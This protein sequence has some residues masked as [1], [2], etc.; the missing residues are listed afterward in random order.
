MSASEQSIRT[1]QE[2]ANWYGQ[3]GQAQ[4]RDRFL[5]L[6]ADALLSAGR[7]EEAEQLRSRLLKVNPHHLLKPFASFAEA[8]K[9]SDVKNYVEGLRRTYSPEKVA[10][11]QESLRNQPE[12]WAKPPASPAPG[13]AGLDP[14]GSRPGKGGTGPSGEGLKVYRLQDEKEAEPPRTVPLGPAAKGGLRPTVSPVQRPT[15]A[16]PANRPV[17]PTPGS[18]PVSTSPAS[19]PAPSAAPPVQTGSASPLWSQT[20]APSPWRMEP[21]EAEL[22]EPTAGSWVATWLFCLLLLSGLALAGFTLG[23]P[24]LPFLGK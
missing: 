20:P 6:A 7:S 2:L 4:M 5:V 23:M 12:G 17:A 10:Q 13:D 19:R 8:M 1:F 24:Y 21:A 9:S 3:N 16:A 15:G 18:R 22:P 14:D 11:L